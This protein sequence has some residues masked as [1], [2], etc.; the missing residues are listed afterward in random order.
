MCQ[1]GIGAVGE[2]KEF[3]A[4]DSGPLTDISELAIGE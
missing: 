4:K 1:I 2:L 3:A